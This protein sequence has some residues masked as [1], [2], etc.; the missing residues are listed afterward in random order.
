MLDNRPPKSFALRSKQKFIKPRDLA[1]LF[2]LPPAVLVAWALPERLWHTL[3]RVGAPIEARLTPPGPAAMKETMRAVL[4]HDTGI[5]LDAAIEELSAT[6]VE[7]LFQML[8]SYRYGGWKPDIVIEGEANLEAARRLD[9]GIIFW[10]SPFV[11]Y[12]L[13]PKMALQKNAVPR[14]HLYHPKHGFSDTQ[15]GFNVLNPIQI[16]AEAAFGVTPVFLSRQ[17]GLPIAL[18]RLAAH[19]RNKGMISISVRE[20][21]SN[22][23]RVPILDGSLVAG[24]S[25]LHLAHATGAP[26]IPVH[27]VREPDRRFRVIIDDPIIVDRSVS[28]AQSTS[29]AAGQYADCLAPLLKAYPG[30]WVGWGTIAVPRGPAPS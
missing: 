9:S 8:R 20:R 25:V 16:K 5:D 30:Q 14:L 6:R 1:I 18:R 15:F 13:V 11:F 4:G 12:Q 27:T 22:P 19:L 2:G 26:I 23:V 29:K 17:P 7:R 24:T 21:G 3:A 10:V 28:R